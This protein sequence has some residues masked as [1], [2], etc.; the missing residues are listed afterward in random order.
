MIYDRCFFFTTINFT[1]FYIKRV[2]HLYLFFIEKIFFGRVV[3]SFL[4]FNTKY[5]LVT[6]S[7]LS[8]QNA[9]E[10]THPFIQINVYQCN[11][12]KVIC[13]ALYFLS[14]LFS[15]FFMFT[16]IF[17]DKFKDTSSLCIIYLIL[18]FIDPLTCSHDPS[19]TWLT[20]HALYAIPR[21]C[22]FASRDHPLAASTLLRI[23]SVIWYATNHHVPA[24]CHY[25]AHTWDT[26]QHSSQSN[27]GLFLRF[28]M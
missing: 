1:F 22:Y 12:Y 2:D 27:A 11:F 10:V 3:L 19:D 14:Y 24:I 4:F 13:I 7:W 18:S 26:V 25:Y 23:V 17:F 6:L 21:I 28:T 15:S 9:V 8:D 16:D 20:L 5:D